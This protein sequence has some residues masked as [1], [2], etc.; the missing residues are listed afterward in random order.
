VGEVGL[1]DG[2]TIDGRHGVAG[3]AAACGDGRGHTQEGAG[4]EY[5]T[6]SLDH[7]KGEKG[8]WTFRGPGARTRRKQ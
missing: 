4:A 7:E 8:T 2:L 6:S 3:H 1:V 5:E